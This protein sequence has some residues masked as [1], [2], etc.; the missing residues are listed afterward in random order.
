MHAGVLFIFF[1]WANSYIVLRRSFIR[2]GLRPVRLPSVDKSCTISSLEVLYLAL[3]CS[4]S[5]QTLCMRLL[6]LTENL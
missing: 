5:G 6:Q 2:M 3:A 1:S 4:R